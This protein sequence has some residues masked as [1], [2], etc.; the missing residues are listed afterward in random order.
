MFEAVKVVM[1]VAN[2]WMGKDEVETAKDFVPL[3]I[4]NEKYMIRVPVL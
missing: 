3:F 4:R 1:Q 2:E